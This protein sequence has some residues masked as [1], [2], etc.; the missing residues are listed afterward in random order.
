MILIVMKICE[1]CRLVEKILSYDEV[2]DTYSESN[3]VNIEVNV[4]NTSRQR[5]VS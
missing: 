2:S 5:L 3:E 1:V 4:G